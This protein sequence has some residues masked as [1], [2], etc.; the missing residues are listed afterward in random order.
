MAV[1]WVD[2]I[3]IYSPQLDT[4]GAYYWAD[5]IALEVYTPIATLIAGPTSYTW[6]PFDLWMG[7]ALIAD[8][9]AY[10]W[11]AQSA[12]L[13]DLYDQEEAKNQGASPAWRFT[14]FDADW[15]VGT[16]IPQSICDPQSCDLNLEAPTDFSD[17]VAS[18]HTLKLYDTTGL[19]DPRSGSFLYPD[20]LDWFGR[21]IRYESGFTFDGLSQYRTLYEG[22]IFDW[23]RVD[24][25]SEIP[26]VEIYSK[27]FIASILNAPLGTADDYGLK[28][29]VLYGQP[30]IQ[31]EDSG[32]TIPEL[33]P[34]K[35][36]LFNNPASPDWD[37]T[38]I[39][40]GGCGTVTVEADTAARQIT[41]YRTG[42][43]VAAGYSAQTKT[44]D[45]PVSSSNTCWYMDFGAGTKKVWWEGWIRFNAFPA[46]PAAQNTSFI[47]LRDSGN[48]NYIELYLDADTRLWIKSKGGV[49]YKWHN[50][51]V[52]A[53]AYRQQWIK[54]ALGWFTDTADGVVRVYF[55]GSEAWKSD[56][57]WVNQECQVLECGPK[58]GSTAEYW[59]LSWKHWYGWDAVTSPIYY[60]A[61]CFGNG[62]IE[63][64]E[65]VYQDGLTITKEA[66]KRSK[67]QR[68]LDRKLNYKR[69]K[70]KWSCK[71]NWLPVSG[72]PWAI[73]WSD[74][75]NP[76][77]GEMM[78]EVIANSTVGNS[79]IGIIED[80]LTTCNLDSRIGDSFTEALADIAL[81]G[82]VTAPT[83]DKLEIDGMVCCTPGVHSVKYTFRLATGETVASPP[84]NSVTT[85]GT[86][87]IIS[88]AGV[89]SGPPGTLGI[90]VYLT[91]AGGSTYKYAGTNWAQ[92]GD[93][94]IGSCLDGDLGAE[95]PLVGTAS[96][97]GIKCN[98]QDTTAGE[99][100]KSITSQLLMNIWCDAG[101]IEL[102]VY[103]GDSPGTAD[104]TLDDSLLNIIPSDT[105][106]EDC[107][108]KI[109]IDWGW[110]DR[111]SDLHYVTRN[112]DLIDLLG[113]NEDNLDL[114]ISQPVALDSAN[115]TLAQDLADNLLIR[116]GYPL[117]KAEIEGFFKTLPRINLWD[118]VSLGGIKFRVYSKSMSFDGC[119][120]G[121]VRFL[122]E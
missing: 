63:S 2:G 93:L 11:V 108:P 84:S 65:Q 31:A 27:D 83:I 58:I 37:G 69:V 103:Q 110:Y 80:I 116:V 26:V 119:K 34:D 36:A 53:G 4:G 7:G 78:F 107:T 111:N 57:N 85:D 114:T 82:P 77:S 17:L 117:D 14:I 44:A 67:R 86:V 5:G 40:P 19:Y 115:V 30:L 79:A 87:G 52:F 39:S 92:W 10:N 15:L 59:D 1:K 13:G 99:A 100:I 102:N 56:W 49:T 106:F 120:I 71:D 98:F 46:I 101:K 50:T 68:K 105:N 25:A 95:P 76:P 29:P 51:D 91:E 23:K 64:V 70:F 121:L 60:R 113:T 42:A 54:I 20:P 33:N 8:P 62:N 66:P 9:A 73:S 118:V 16:E 61:E 104:W 109:T 96:G 97:Y 22:K 55:D 94:I 75:Y 21:G 6:T 90:N 43:G 122:G 28:Q 81:P 48:T 47:R 72:V 45:T 18:E 24:D 41:S 3:S 32:D 35:S 12:F 74:Y 88:L 38:T 89:E 112:S